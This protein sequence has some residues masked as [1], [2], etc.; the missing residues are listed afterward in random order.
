MRK[1][2]AECDRERILKIGYEVM[3]FSGLLFMDHP[4]E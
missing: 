1:F 4:I 2:A 3:K